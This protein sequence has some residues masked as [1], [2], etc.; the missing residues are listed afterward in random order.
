MSLPVLGKADPLK[1]VE[2][3]AGVATLSFGWALVGSMN[4]ARVDTTQARRLLS[5]VVIVV[6]VAGGALVGLDVSTVSSL[7]LFLHLWLLS[8]H[9]LP[10]VFLPGCPPSTGSLPPF[11]VC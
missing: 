9:Y 3:V 11:G 5:V 2:V 10:F 4:V 6:V 1:V 8:G 7:L